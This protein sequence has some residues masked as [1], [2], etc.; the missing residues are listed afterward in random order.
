MCTAQFWPAAVQACGTV[1]GK[2][3][4]LRLSP[5]LSVQCWGVCV[6]G[7]V[8][9]WVCGCVGVCV[10]CGCVGVCVGVFVCVCACMFKMPGLV[11]WI[12]AAL[13]SMCRTVQLNILCKQITWLLPFLL[14]LYLYRLPA[15]R[16]YSAPGKGASSSHQ[17]QPEALPPDRPLQCL[18][19][20]PHPQ[21]KYLLHG[22]YWSSYSGRPLSPH[23]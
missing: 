7:W 1:I 22:L 11:L 12:W 4:C 3:S 9:V 10:G 20:E 5:H 13:A 2:S 17:C 6:C 23:W 16:A 19:W 8:G 21:T 15:S 14:Q 18:H